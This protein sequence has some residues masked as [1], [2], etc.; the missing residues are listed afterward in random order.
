M[1]TRSAWDLPWI[2]D[3]AKVQALVNQGLSQRN[4]IRTVRESAG[5]TPDQRNSCAS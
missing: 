5:Q 2:P 3:A 4:A 1:I